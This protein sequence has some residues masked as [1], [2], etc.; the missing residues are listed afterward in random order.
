MTGIAKNKPPYTIT[1]AIIDLVAQ[2]GEATGRLSVLTDHEKK[3]RLR[4]VNRIQT[5][6]GSLAIEGNTLSENQITAILDGKRIIAP[7]REIREVANAH[8]AY[9]L[10]KKW[11][12]DSESD[13]LDAH[14][15]L[16]D[17]L[18]DDAGLYRHGG[19]GVMA[20]D[21]LLH[22][23]PPADRVSRLTLTSTL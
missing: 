8:K 17:G 9:D 22:M 3:L 5:I 13:L 18:T 6:Y 12:P 19:G 14:R 11:Y 4:R 23:A 16:M 7:A 1:P 15:I 21:Q 10:F 2:T 20:G